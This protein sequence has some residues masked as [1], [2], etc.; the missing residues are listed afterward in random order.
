MIDRQTIDKILDSPEIVEV[1]QEFVPLKKRGVNYLGL[2]PFHNEK[3]IIH[4][5]PSKRYS[6]VSDVVK[7]AMLLTS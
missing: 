2:C 1:I 3:L 6:N 5:L 4:C 7:Q